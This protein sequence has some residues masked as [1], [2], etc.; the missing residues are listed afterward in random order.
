MKSVK[1]LNEKQRHAKD[2]GVILDE[3]LEEQINQCTSRLTAERNLRFQM[4]NTEVMSATK[5]TIDELGG[6]I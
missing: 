4:D 1:I 5:E 3:A 2:L 6:L